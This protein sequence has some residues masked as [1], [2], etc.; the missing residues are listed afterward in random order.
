MRLGALF[1]AVC[2]VVIA[3]SAG[4]TMYLG[5]GFSGAEAIIVA[6]AV[7]TALGLYNIFSSRMGV[8]SMVGSQLGELSRGNFELARQVN[9]ISRRLSTVEGR[10]ESAQQRA[11]AA[12]DPLAVEISELS[13][14]VRQL[15]ETVA[16]HE[17]RFNEAA[18]SATAPA[19]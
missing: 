6:L 10:V 17:T 8:R 16:T 13:T 14:L 15:A 9:E 4:A 19:A 7:L 11:R 2:M 18:K 1:I 5:F 3:A 12:V